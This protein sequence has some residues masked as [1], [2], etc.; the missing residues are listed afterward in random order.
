MTYTSAKII[1]Q[2]VKEEA[3]LIFFKYI[4]CILGGGGGGGG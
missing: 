3:Y 4:T 1:R 2:M